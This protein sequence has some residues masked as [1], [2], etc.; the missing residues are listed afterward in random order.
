LCLFPIFVLERKRT[1]GV[2]VVLRDGADDVGNK[3]K[4]SGGGGLKIKALPSE[5]AP[6]ASGEGGRKKNGL[7]EKSKGGYGWVDKIARKKNETQT[8]E[9]GCEQAR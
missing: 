9:P 4:G 5:P 7:G 2:I 3:D 1:R 6:V 8:R